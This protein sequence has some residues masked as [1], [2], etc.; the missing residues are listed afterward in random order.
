MLGSGTGVVASILPLFGTQRLVGYGLKLAG[1]PVYLSRVYDPVTNPENLFFSS[2]IS[3]LL[4]GSAELRFHLRKDLHLHLSAAY[5][6]ISNGGLKEPNKGMNYPTLLAGVSYLMTNEAL[7]TYTRQRTWQNN[8]P[9]TY[10]LSALYT[11]RATGGLTDKRLDLYGLDAS[12]NWRHGMLG[13]WRSGIEWVHDPKRT[14]EA[15]RRGVSLQANHAGLHTGEYLTAGRFALGMALGMYIWEPDP[16]KDLVYQRYSLSVELIR[17]IRMA[18]T[19]RAHR[20]VADFA[21]I[22]LGFVL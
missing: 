7:P 9:V 10:S 3:V 20:S 16:G 8:R 21:D 11:S 12:F 5:M 18:I 4:I 1:G 17:H 14:L 2:S 15:S 6:H 13:E 19:L 22:R